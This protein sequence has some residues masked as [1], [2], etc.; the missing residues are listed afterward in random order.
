[1][2]C[3]HC[4]K[5]IKDQFRKVKAFNLGTEYVLVE[6]YKDLFLGIIK[7]GTKLVY[8]SMNLGYAKFLIKGRFYKKIAI[9]VDEAFII[10]RKEVK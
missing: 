4:G 10:V 7:K 2:K 9:D 8:D 1:M 3:P 5:Q 6:D